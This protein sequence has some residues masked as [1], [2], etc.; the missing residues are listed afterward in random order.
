[1][2]ITIIN[3]YGNNI[4]IKRNSM[5][6]DQFNEILRLTPEKDVVESR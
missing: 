6:Q 5:V 2:I 4:I 3:Q 1:M